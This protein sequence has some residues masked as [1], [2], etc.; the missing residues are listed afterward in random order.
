ME[1]RKKI[2]WICRSSRPQNLERAFWGPIHSS[3]TRIA[4]NFML[5]TGIFQVLPS[6]HIDKHKIMQSIFNNA[7]KLQTK[8][9]SLLAKFKILPPG[10]SDAF[11][12][13]CA[14]FTCNFHL[15]NSTAK[16][17]VQ[18]LFQKKILKIHQHLDKQNRLQILFISTSF[19]SMG[20]WSC[21]MNSGMNASV[22]TVPFI[23]AFSRFFLFITFQSWI[24]S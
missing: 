18:I 2:A 22:S 23:N 21:W 4:Q 1:I 14:T 19:H 5:K 11:N 10:K 3:S 16:T 17:F 15:S 6:T 20:E 24:I 9:F 12:P 8:N 7:E 13:K